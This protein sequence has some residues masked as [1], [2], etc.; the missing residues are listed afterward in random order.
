M[1]APETVAG[2][3]GVTG[4]SRYGVECRQQ[5]VGQRDRG[6]RVEGGALPEGLVP[7]GLEGRG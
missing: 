5:V 7:P 3:S 1:M 6:V 2:C 4:V